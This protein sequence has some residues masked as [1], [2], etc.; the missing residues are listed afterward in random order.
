MNDQEELKYVQ[1]LIQMV[2]K[3][4]KGAPEGTLRCE[5]A[6]GKYP[7]YYLIHKEEREKYPRGR[8]LRKNEHDLARQIAQKEYDLQILEMLREKERLLKQTTQNQNSLT[9][10]TVY[11]KLPET[12]KRL[13]NPYV[14]PD[15]QYIREWE[16]DGAAEQ[17]PFPFMNSFLTEKGETVRSKTEKIIADKLF[18]MNVPYKYE[19]MLNLG[20]D[21]IIYP[22]FTMLNVRTRETLFLEH[23]GMMDNPEYCKKAIEK[24]ELYEKNGIYQ[25]EG[26]L[27]TFECSGKG[28]NMKQVETLL[29]RHLS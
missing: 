21:G 4:L 2:Q 17:N 1:S 23:F 22:D 18:Y 5:M 24:I 15:D 7:Q 19:A 25:G 6:Q 26:L 11:Q 16:M 9:L 27:V 13:V 14:L 20:K 10:A 8:F 3:S 12:R 28:V 29:S